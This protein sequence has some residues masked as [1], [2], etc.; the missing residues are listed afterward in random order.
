MVRDR[1]AVSP[2]AAEAARARDPHR[3]RQSD[4]RIVRARRPHSRP[5]GAYRPTAWELPACRTAAK[6]AA[7][8]AATGLLVYPQAAHLE[9]FEAKQ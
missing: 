4:D 6:G 7:F 1:L 8:A 5:A 9:Y 2:F 3:R